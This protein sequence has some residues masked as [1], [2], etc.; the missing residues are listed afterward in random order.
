MGLFRVIAHPAR[1]L[2]TL[3]TALVAMIVLVIPFLV[4][5]QS[6]QEK[7]DG[8][9]GTDTLQGTVQD[10]RGRPIAGATV[11]VQLK[12]ETE[13]RTTLTD[14]A[15]NYRFP[16]LREG[17]YVLRAEMAGYAGA[18]HDPIVLRQKDAKSI[19]LTLSSAN[20]A[21]AQSSTAGSSATGKPEFFDEPAFTVAGVTDTTNLGGHGSNT[22]VRSK[23]SL[24]REAAAL[25]NESRPSASSIASTENNLRDAAERQ[26]ENFEANHRLG[27][28]LVNEGKSKEALPYLEQASRLNGRNYENTFLLARAYA[29]AAKYDTA[30]TTAQTLLTVPNKSGQEKA[31][32]HHLLGD[33]AEKQGNPLE[34]VQEYQRAAELNPSEANL[35]DWGAELLL[36]RAA[37]PAI[38]V[39]T[40]G[41]RLFPRSVRMLVGLGVAWY[42]RGAY[43]QAAQCLCEASDLNPDDANPYLFMGKMQGAGAQIASVQNTGTAQAECVADSLKRFVRR[44][45]DNALANYYYALSLSKQRKGM[46]DT[47]TVPQVEA[48]LEKAIHLD[49]KL[50][51]GYLQLG[52]LYSDRKDFAHAIAAYQKATAASPESEEAHYRLAQ[53]YRRTGEK[54]KA[55]QELQLY[56]QISRRKEE[57]VERQRHEIQQFV[58]ALRDSGSAS[59]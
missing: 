56:Q 48:L 28:L 13:T 5:G 24:A 27:E 47:Q 42:A 40:K 30:R 9:V 46:E 7:S 55:Q 12:G 43:D 18:T 41:N 33:V 25:S 1:R 57:E 49:P 3:P 59:H 17:V 19:D 38:E 21:A 14:S 31:E 6:F 20:G 29:E 44:Q 52:I 10:S 51:A 35:F 32:L 22:I 45:P 2:G 4:Q 37:E 36:H 53:A 11:Y 58:Y 34:A 26:P 16:A 15:G 39:F 54:L 50:G 8:A 23:E